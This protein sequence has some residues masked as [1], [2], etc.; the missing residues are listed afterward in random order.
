MIEMLQMLR[1]ERSEKSLGSPKREKEEEG[2][3]KGKAEAVKTGVE[4]PKLQAVE[5]AEAA[6]RCGD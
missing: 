3:E 6:M 5:S 1:S 4:F 2:E